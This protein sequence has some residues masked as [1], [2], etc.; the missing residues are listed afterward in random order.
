MAVIGLDA[1]YLSVKGKGVSRYQHN[2]I[3]GLSKIDKKNFYYIFLNKRNILPELPKQDNFNYCLT[4]IPK[5]IIWD[6]FQIPFII[7]KYKLD[8]YHS[9]IE[10]LPI[11]A[12]TRFILGV[13]ELP[14]Y[15]MKLIRHSIY[16]S[17]Y[18]RLSYGYN[19]LFFYYSLKKAH[20]IMVNSNSTKLDL[21]HRYNVDENK[22]R[23]SYF[24]ADEM[25]YP[26]RDEEYLFNIKKHYGAETGYILHI[27]TSD[28][29]ENTPLVI[30]AYQRAFHKLKLPKKL[31]ICGD[32][33]PEKTGLNK[34]IKDLNLE[35]RIIFTG[36]KVGKDLVQLYQAADMFIEPSLYEGFGLQ[37]VEAMACGT[38]VIVS[39]VFSLPEVIADAGILVSPTDIEGLS[40]A[41]VQVATDS[42]L[43]D[44]M[45]KISLERAKFFCWDRAAKEVLAVYEE[46][47][48]E[49][50]INKF[51]KRICAKIR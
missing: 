28:P 48:R 16:D 17:L 41:I 15:R 42:V 24:A 23:L 21:I 11:F 20:I 26:A 46:I 22:I 19:K 30:H 5:R 47:I 4:Y 2:L 43:Q 27:S 39:N 1:T 18:S 10:T 9:L 12:K 33:K 13:I 51:F 35:D 31:I 32:A 29:R 14:D 49:E 40:S 36:H 44:R 37:V 38:P 45:R 50:K 25:F 3:K 6:Q 8:I 7:K 34:L